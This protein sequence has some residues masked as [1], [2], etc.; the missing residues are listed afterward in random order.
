MALKLQKIQLNGNMVL[1]VSLCALGLMLT[2]WSYIYWGVL[3]RSKA[4]TVMY[5]QIIAMS[6]NQD[7][8]LLGPQDV[9]ALAAVQPD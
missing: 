9:E 4:G 6:L 3:Y 8:R 5:A 1:I 7:F 2:T